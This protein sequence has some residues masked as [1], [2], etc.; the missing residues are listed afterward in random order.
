M[1]GV[2]LSVRVRLRAS[3]RVTVR[4]RLRVRVRF[5]IRVRFRKKMATPPPPSV[6]DKVHRPSCFQI[7]SAFI[8]ML[9]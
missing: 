6:E 9:S 7:E 4:A 2:R 5:R 8:L 1:D 3:L